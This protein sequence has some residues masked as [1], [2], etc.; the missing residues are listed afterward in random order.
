[1]GIQG[2]LPQLKPIQNP[3][4]LRR[5]EGQ[6][7][8]IDGYAWLHKAAYSCA[9]E[10]ATGKPTEKYL[11][12]FIKKFALLKTFNIKP[13][14]I[15]DGDGVPVKKGTE[16]KRHDKRKEN[17][18]IADRL[19]QSGEKKNAVEFYQKCVDVTPEM[20]K[21]IIDYCKVN[22][23]KY[24]VAPFEADPQM[25]YLEEKG[26]IHG[27][28]AEDSDLLVFGC[29]K[30][31]TKLNDFGE[32]IEICRDDFKKLPR[33]FPLGDLTPEE[34]R[35]LVC[36]SGC[37]YTDGIPKVGLL[38]AM[39]FVLRSRDIRR[40]IL[41]I[42]REGKFKIPKTFM[43]E[44]E[45]ACFGFLYQRVFCPLERKV[46]TFHKIPDGLLDSDE[47]K[48]EIASCIGPVINI[49]SH[50]KCITLNECDVDHEVHLR[51]AMGDLSPYDYSKPLVN[52]EQTVQLVSKSATNISSTRLVPTNKNIINKPAVPTKSIDAFFKPRIAASRGKVVSHSVSSY[53]LGTRLIPKYI[54][55]PTETVKR[56]KLIKDDEDNHPVA[57][58]A[59]ST[60]RFFGRTSSI[61]SVQGTS[62]LSSQSIYSRASTVVQTVEKRTTVEEEHKS[63]QG[64]SDEST[65]IPSSYPL[66]ADKENIENVDCAQS[67]GDSQKENVQPSQ[68]ANSNPSHLNSELGNRHNVTP[69]STNMT[70]I[71]SIKQSADEPLVQPPTDSHQM[72]VIQPHKTECNADGDSFDDSI[73]DI[74]EQE[75]DEE[76]SSQS[77]LIARKEEESCIQE[78]KSTTRPASR[79]N[80]FSLQQFTYSSVMRQSGAREPLASHDINKKTINSTTR[81]L[82][83]INQL[84][85]HRSPSKSSHTLQASRRLISN[86]AHV[87]SSGISDPV[88]NSKHRIEPSVLASN[89]TGIDKNV[90]HNGSET[91]NSASQVRPISRSM[92]LLSQFRYQPR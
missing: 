58:K 12:F 6:T 87:S 77:H 38:T 47:T 89:N 5:Y 27:I 44:Y 34:T 68:E 48:N 15:F 80:S 49:S 11:N 17:R 50:E 84:K 56:R 24:I 54:D 43:K 81:K 66:H 7:L 18:E 39:K 83:S 31:I 16:K 51:Q 30:L 62:E 25:V 2:L 14:L 86:N 76:V 45:H 21:C 61:V 8:G 41:Q 78:V 74:D 28:I 64:D 9:Y 29:R 37:D 32:C 85:R 65:D 46:L 20:A 57:G 60:S 88:V 35:T 26:L 79:G 19:W 42:Q 55:K 69:N 23:I 4:S 40:I 36:L 10:L 90:S 3:V 67:N 71:L 53:N 52:R 91:E 63:E 33:K 22:N 73:T 1:M 13:Y 70:T 59:I 72:E 75:W 82:V 92:S